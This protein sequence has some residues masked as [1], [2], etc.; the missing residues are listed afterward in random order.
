[1]QIKL[2]EYQ[3]QDFKALET[4]IKETW[5]Y[6]DFSSPKIAIKLARVFLSSCLT[7]YTFSRVAVVD[8]NIVGIIMVNNIAK[9]KCPLSNRLLQIKSILSLLSS[10]EG[11]KISKIFSN[12]NGIDKQLLNENNKIYSAEL[13]LFIVSSSCR[14]K[15]IGKMLF[16]SVLNYMKQK[17]L[18]EFYLFT[19]TSCNY[20]FYEH[21]GM[22]RRLEKKHIF[23]IKEQQA[24]MNFFIYDYQC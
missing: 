9:H 19:D 2:R 17:K 15:G 21:Q 12:I 5:H 4:I 11:R 22:K 24:I 20:G 18:K 10:K 23:N 8:G 16:Q 14:G 3:K 13:V 7:N 6:D 1:M